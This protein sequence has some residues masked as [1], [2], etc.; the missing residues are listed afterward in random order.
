MIFRRLV[1]DDASGEEHVAREDTQR[2][3]VKVRVARDVEAKQARQRVRQGLRL[4]PETHSTWRREREGSQ[5][6]FGH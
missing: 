6:P 4:P 5:T 1:E 3:G 2:R